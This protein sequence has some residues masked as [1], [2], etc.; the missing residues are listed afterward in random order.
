MSHETTLREH[1]QL[2]LPALFI[3]LVIWI[4]ARQQELETTW[5]TGVGVVVTQ[6]PPYMDVSRSPD[7]VRIRVRYPS[8]LHNWVVARNFSLQVDARGLFITE[9]ERLNDQLVLQR[10]D[11]QV[12]PRLV[13]RLGLPHSIHVIDVEPSQV[14]LTAALR[15]LVVQVDIVTTGSLP[16]H[17]ELIAPPQAQPSEVQVTGSVA[18]LAQLAETKRLPTRPVNLGAV[19][20]SGQVFPTL[21]LPPEVYLVNPAQR[22]VTVDIGVVEQRERRVYEQVPV[23]VLALPGELTALIDPPAVDV[24]VEGPASSLNQLQSEDLEIYPVRDPVPEPGPPQSI[25]VE[26]HLKPSAPAQLRGQVRVLRVIPNLVNFEF[27]PAAPLPPA[28]SP[29]VQD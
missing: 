18:A 20:G 7:E 19:S 22:T 9:T 14:Q 21:E 6:V 26:A 1:L 27:V 17:L 15:T 12:E 29:A 11:Y 8:E 3:A 4:I 25:G 28:E 16:R 24:E 23:T 2:I 5:V 13:E 10:A